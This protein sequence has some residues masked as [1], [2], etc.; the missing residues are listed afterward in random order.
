V[1]YGILYQCG[2]YGQRK[3]LWRVMGRKCWSIRKSCFAIQFR[4]ADTGAMKSPQPFISEYPDDMRHRSFTQALLS[5]LGVRHALRERDTQ[6]DVS[7]LPKATGTNDQRICGPIVGIYARSSS[8]SSQDI[9]QSLCHLFNLKDGSFLKMDFDIF[10][11][12]NLNFKHYSVVLTHSSILQAIVTRNS[13][14]IIQPKLTCN[15]Q[16]PNRRTISELGEVN[17]FLKVQD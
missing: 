6:P 16:P 1:E 7:H 3:P 11:L 5:L 9:F 10:I 8:K 13:E 2:E 14:P 17:S 15:P 12:N 4:D